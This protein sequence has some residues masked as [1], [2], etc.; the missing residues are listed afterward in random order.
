MVNIFNTN[1]YYISVQ[2]VKD[3]TNK[4]EL[5]ALTDEE[6]KTLIVKAEI[7]VNDY[8]WYVMGANII[9]QTD[10]TKQDFKIA[11]FYVVE[12]IFVNNDLIKKVNSNWVVSSESSWDRSVSF[13]T[14]SKTNN[15]K[16]LWIN[17]FAK[18]ILDKYRKIF[19]KQVI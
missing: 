5:S 18:K 4:T 9:N 6:I 7:S 3:S 19:Y 2:E 12:Q 15:L 16:I 13:E 10:Q 17:E 8:L 14:N 11:T 1:I